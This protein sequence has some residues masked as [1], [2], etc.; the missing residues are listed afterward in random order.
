M[1]TSGMESRIKT[2]GSLSFEYL[3]KQ[4]QP[5]SKRS[6]LGALTDS[7]PTPTSYVLGHL[8]PVYVR[9]RMG[10]LL[11][12]WLVLLALYTPL[13]MLYLLSPL[14]SRDWQHTT[15]CCSFM[16]CPG[17]FIPAISLLYSP[18]R[19]N[20]PA[21]ELLESFMQCITFPRVNPTCIFYGVCYEP[22]LQH[23]LLALPASQTCQLSLPCSSIS[24]LLTDSLL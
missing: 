6:L 1:L 17:T 20:S 11:P 10:P 14:W 9:R 21:R 3:R 15:Y 19:W 18:S 5:W 13:E 24:L 23:W 22:V 12:F 4:N 8:Q 2:Q 7:L 16:V